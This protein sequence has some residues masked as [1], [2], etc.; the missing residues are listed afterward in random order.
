MSNDGFF[1]AGMAGKRQ[2]QIQQL[3]RSI[4][5]WEAHVANLEHTIEELRRSRL[6]WFNT[7]VKEGAAA[8]VFA[9]GFKEY[10]G[11]GFKAVFGNEETK[12]RVEDQ[13]SV[14]RNK[15]FLK[16]WDQTL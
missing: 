16:Y 4:D 13:K 12:R 3:N 7:A 9:D 5:K 2:E 1:W 8:Q 14:E 10:T 15:T 11:K 6:F